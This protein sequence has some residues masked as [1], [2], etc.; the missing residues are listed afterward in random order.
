MKMP[1]PAH[2]LCP[3]VPGSAPLDQIVFHDRV[4]SAHASNG[5]YATVANRVVTDDLVEP[6]L[7]RT[8]TVPVSVADIQAHAVR[9]LDRVVFDDPVIAA[10]G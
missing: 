5:F 9:S 8:R 6:R 4:L 1:E 7:L 2:P 10:T 3:G